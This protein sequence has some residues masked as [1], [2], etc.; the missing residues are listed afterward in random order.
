MTYRRLDNA[1]NPSVNIVIWSLE[2]QS[3][4]SLTLLLPVV[5]D[6]QCV[7]SL[8]LRLLLAALQSCSHGSGYLC[9][10]SCPN[11]NKWY[12]RRRSRPTFGTYGADD[13]WIPGSDYGSS[14]TRVGGDCV[15]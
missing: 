3:G 10:R 2:T 8:T 13:E 7:P 5:S 9:T 11:Q 12:L 1:V 15:H 4:A 14:Q 6:T